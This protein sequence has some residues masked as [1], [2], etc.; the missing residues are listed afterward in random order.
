MFKLFKR[1]PAKKLR[2]EYHL[3]LEKALHAQRN[4][5]IR[6]YSFLT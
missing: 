2:K 6:E 1:D 5:N 3:K 4:G